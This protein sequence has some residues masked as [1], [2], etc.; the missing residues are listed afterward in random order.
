MHYR[1]YTREK[2]LALYIIVTDR[3]KFVSHITKK[4]IV[5]L[6]C[7]TLITLKNAS[8]DHYS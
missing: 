3:K 2:V 7:Q 1:G 6:K 8:S 4:H 5:G